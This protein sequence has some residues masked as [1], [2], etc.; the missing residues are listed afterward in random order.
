MCSPDYF[1]VEYVINPWM[2]GN[3]GQ[4]NAQLAQQQW[5]D[6]RMALEQHA[7]IELIKPRQGLPD[8]VFTANAG[9][10][11]K[12]KAV[13]SRFRLKERQGEESYFSAWF[14]DYGFFCATWPQEV[15]FEGAGDAL[16]DRALTLLWV[17]FGFRTGMRALA[18][19][20]SFF[21]CRVVGLKL[22]DPRFYHLD[23]CFCPLPGGYLMYYPA[24][25]SEESLN[26]IA[27]YVASDKLVAI[28]EEDAT[29]FACNAVDLNNHIFMNSATTAL[30]NKLKSIGLTPVLTP[31][32]EFLKAGGTA[33]CLTLKLVEK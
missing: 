3:R 17:G 1:G 29:C 13:I 30:Q 23:T 7:R 5:N 31:L 18:L 33:K 8:M 32:S 24:A 6:L 12:K 15:P 20:E 11:L 2:S 4:T 27:S 26:T 9:L 19:L 22:V 16:W 25:F 14:K 10:V 28:T 21:N